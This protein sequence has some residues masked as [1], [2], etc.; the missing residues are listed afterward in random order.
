M[1]T[2][3]N[4]I[5]E[6]QKPG[7][8]HR[9]GGCVTICTAVNYGALEVDEEGKPRYRDIEKCIECGL[10]HA[11]CPE[12]EELKEEMKRKVA[13]SAPMGRVIETTVSRALDRDVLA[14]ATDGGVVTALLLHLFQTGRIDGAIVAKRKGPFQREPILAESREDILASAGF[15]MDTSHGVKSF[16]DRYLTHSTIEEFD[17]LM[18]RGLRRVA[19][20]GTPCQVNA[21]RRMETLGIVP[22]DSIRYIFGLFC[23][24]NF[25]FGENEQREMARLGD[26]D[27]E[28]VRRVNIKEEFRVHLSSGETRRIPLQDME[29]MRRHACS[30][31]RDYAAEFADVSFGGVGAPEG[32]T[33]VIT[34]TP[35]GRALFADARNK[36]VQEY[37]R[38]SDPNYATNALNT[39]IRC[40]SEKK[41][42]ARRNRRDLG[43]GV[44][45]KG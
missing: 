26:F 5:Q 25:V 42:T 41:K 13:W 30:Y 8:C 23:S 12:N 28:D 24:G 19:L 37:D 39:V 17:P 11:I 33:T 36:A 34:R 27:W 43:R 35:H 29:S 3:F 32:W 40:S 10:C 38:E 18:R 14:R 4:L 21:V 6:V 16:G 1:K 45:V 9:C 15:F 44:Q 20:V 22:S 2:F 31:C 7:L